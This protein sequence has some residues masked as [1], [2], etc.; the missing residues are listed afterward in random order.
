MTYLYIYFLNLTEILFEETGTDYADVMKMN[1]RG[2]V[3]T[4]VKKTEQ[5]TRVIHN[6]L[7]KGF[8]VASHSK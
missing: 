1:V 2:F 7:M 5:E 3:Q 6:V 4:Y 8:K